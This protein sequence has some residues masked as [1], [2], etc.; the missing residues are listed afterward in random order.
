MKL[1]EDMRDLTAA[2]TG[3]IDGA[4]RRGL[5]RNEVHLLTFLVAHGVGRVG[6]WGFHTSNSGP[7]S[8][9]VDK[10]LDELY[11]DGVVTLRFERR[12]EEPLYVPVDV[13]KLPWVRGF[14]E[15]QVARDTSYSLMEVARLSTEELAMLDYLLAPEL[16][17]GEARREL[18][19]KKLDLTARL[20]YKG[21]LNLD[22]AADL[23]GLDK[24]AIEGKV[25]E[26]RRSEEEILEELEASVESSGSGGE[27]C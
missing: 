8:D 21:V 23:S 6:E 11:D 2:I 17:T 25:E 5:L 22:M 20:V 4:G 24:K 14:T 15:Y 1:Y 10:I 19:E 18:E 12:L 3:V 26:L 9:A 7:R 13:D 27:T 16:F